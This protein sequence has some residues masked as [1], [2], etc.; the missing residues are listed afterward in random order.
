MALLRSMEFY[1]APNGWLYLLPGLIVYGLA[2]WKRPF[3][4]VL[5]SVFAMKAAFETLN[6]NPVEY[7]FLAVLGAAVS[8][9]RN[10]N[11]WRWNAAFFLMGV[12]LSLW[13]FRTVEVLYL[14]GPLN[15][16]AAYGM[17]SGFSIAGVRALF[18]WARTAAAPSVK[19]SPTTHEG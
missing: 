6:G 11:E 1:L 18:C 8:A 15:L 9:S 17:I 12:F 5:V 4:A 13:T 16:P 2:W 3:T 7:A 10:R 19:K 14:A